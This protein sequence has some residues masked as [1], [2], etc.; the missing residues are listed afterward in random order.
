M[1]EKIT[2]VLFAGSA[3]FSMPTLRT[4]HKRGLVCAVLTNC[5][6]RA[7]RGRQVQ[8][9]CVAAFAQSV[10]L[11]LIQHKFLRTDAREEVAHF[12]PQLM[13][14]VAYG[15][16][17]GPRF[18][19]LFPRGAVNVHPSLLP[20]FR[21]PA[22]VPATIL[23]GDAC[24]G[25]TLQVMALAMDEGDVLLQTK[26]NV[27]DTDDSESVL[28][29]LADDGACE[30][31]RFIDNVDEIYAA[32][33]QQDNTQ[34]VYCTKLSPAYGRISWME[35]AK[36]VLCIARAFSKPYWGAYAYYQS[37]GEKSLQ[38]LKLWHMHLVDEVAKTAPSGTVLGCDDKHGILIQTA[39]GI[40]GCTE[41]QLPTR[42]RLFWKSFV[43]G[44]PNI[45]HTRLC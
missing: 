36:M 19:G 45:M 11:P 9:N 26:R 27:C 34:A 3:E 44:E 32:A 33:R 7:G 14:C 22:P 4:L 30:V 13:V 20:R 18:L 42:K 2:R 15:K 17:F 39:Q 40:V 1:K 5:N 43:Q 12:A 10:G 21:G 41:L 29:I 31:N 38:I 24:T 35:N 28:K 16:I 37:T 25:V 23:A 6:T 8:Q